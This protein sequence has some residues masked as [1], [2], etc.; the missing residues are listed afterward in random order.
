MST[1][2]NEIGVRIL[3]TAKERVFH[4][5]EHRDERPI[6]VVFETNVVADSFNN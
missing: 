2:L 4:Y 1:F 6:V 3:Q 5:L